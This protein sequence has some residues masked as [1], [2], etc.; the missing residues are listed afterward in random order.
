MPS[1]F[2]FNKAFV[3]AFVESDSCFYSS[4]VFFLSFLIFFRKLVTVIIEEHL[5]KS[6]SK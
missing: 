6:Y 2:F 4:R 3:S 1:E 5:P